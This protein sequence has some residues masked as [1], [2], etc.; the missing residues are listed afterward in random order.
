MVSGSI[1]KSVSLAF[2]PAIALE[3]YAEGLWQAK[4]KFL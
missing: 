4:L 1:Q 2:L 3:R